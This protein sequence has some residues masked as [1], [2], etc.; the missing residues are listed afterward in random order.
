MEDNFEFYSEFNGSQ[1]SEYWHFETGLCSMEP[2][3]VTQLIVYHR[4]SHNLI[5]SALENALNLQ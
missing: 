5:E 3:A 4:K 2:Y 1:Y